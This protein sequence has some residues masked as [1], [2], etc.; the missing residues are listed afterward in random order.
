MSSVESDT[1]ETS[2]K[3]YLAIRIPFFGFGEQNGDGEHGEVG[4]SLHGVALQV[5]NEFFYADAHLAVVRREE[6]HDERA[7]FGQL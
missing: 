2:K 5:R 3:E 4:Q 6:T 1:T 7:F